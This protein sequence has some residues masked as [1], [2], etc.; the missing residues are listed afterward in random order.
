M[1]DYSYGRANQNHSYIDQT[2]QNCITLRIWQTIVMGE[3]IR[4]IFM[5]VDQTYTR[6]AL[7]CAWQ[8]IIT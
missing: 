6:I 1:A 2:Y 5:Y 7:H 4:I 8:T 3:P